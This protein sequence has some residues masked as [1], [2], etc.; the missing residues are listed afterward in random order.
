MKRLPIGL[1]MQLQLQITE[2]KKYIDLLKSMSHTA[3]EANGNMLVSKLISAT[4]RASG[5][6][7]EKDRLI[8]F[9][10][11]SLSKLECFVEVIV[12]DLSRFGREYAQNGP[13]YRADGT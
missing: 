1:I 2:A 9:T 8:Y 5:R 10:K 3:L 4:E 11:M 7:A 13:L 6:V 12:K